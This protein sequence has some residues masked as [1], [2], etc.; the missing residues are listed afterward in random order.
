MQVECSTT[1]P[2]NAQWAMNGR[3]AVGLDKTIARSPDNAMISSSQ[4]KDGTCQKTQFTAAKASVVLSLLSSFWSFSLRVLRCLATGQHRMKAQIQ[5]RRTLTARHFSQA[6]HDARALE[7]VQCPAHS[8]YMRSVIAINRQ[9]HRMV[10]GLRICAPIFV[11]IM[12]QQYA[13]LTTLV[14]RDDNAR[15]GNQRQY[16]SNNTHTSN[17]GVPIDF[18]KIGAIQ[19]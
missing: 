5:P 12:R 13:F 10:F 18:S 8:K 7:G 14:N 16:V 4:G 2:L 3:N 19:C 11:Q 1:G 9:V 17:I 6:E 15:D